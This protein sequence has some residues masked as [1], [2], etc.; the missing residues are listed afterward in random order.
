MKDAEIIIPLAR[1]TSLRRTHIEPGTLTAEPFGGGEA[2]IEGVDYS[3][4]LD[5]G[6][7]RPLR[8][9]GRREFYVFR[10]RHVD[11]GVAIEAEQQAAAADAAALTGE[12]DADP[13]QGKPGARARL[14]AIQD[15][16][17][18]LRSDMDRLKTGVAAV[19]GRALGT[20]AACAAAIRDLCDAHTA[21]AD[22]VIQ[23]SRGIEAEARLL[24]VG[25]AVLRRKL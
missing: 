23:A 1:P 12:V 25:L 13:E 24:D 22:A 6:D 11:P 8:P 18:A 17:V 14:Q 20:V 7:V 21:A 10:F 3:V 19:K 5:S 2:L 9:F 15:G 4:D 16:A